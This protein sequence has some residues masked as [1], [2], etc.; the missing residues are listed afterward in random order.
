MKI[1]RKQLR[2]IIKEEIQDVVTQT[3]VGGTF[4]REKGATYEDIHIDIHEFDLEK[5]RWGWSIRSAI[6]IDESFTWARG[7]TSEILNA[8]P[9]NDDQRIA[10]RYWKCGK[11]SPVLN[12]PFYTGR[13]DTDPKSNLD[14]A[15]NYIQSFSKHLLKRLEG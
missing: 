2:Q 10:I 14:S 3:G 1:T 8:L 6:S 13:Y 7:T 12:R 5:A 15:R 4:E 11:A 9:T